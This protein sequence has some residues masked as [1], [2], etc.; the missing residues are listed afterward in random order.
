MEHNS[1]CL[2]LDDTPLSKKRF[3]ASAGGLPAGKSN[4]AGNALSAAA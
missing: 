4:I 3:S 1:A 2:D